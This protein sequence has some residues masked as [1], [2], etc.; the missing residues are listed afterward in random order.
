MATQKE[1]VETF[2][3]LHEREGAFLVPAS[4]D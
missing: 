2:K 4:P 1:K 3:A